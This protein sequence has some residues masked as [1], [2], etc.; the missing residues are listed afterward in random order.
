MTTEQHRVRTPSIRDVASAAGV[1]YQT[2]SRVINDHPSIRPETKQRVVEAM[3]ALRYRPNPA[4]RALV[5]SRSRTIGAITVV[6]GDY[7]PST[8][9]SAVE[10]AAR[11]YGYWVTA[12]RISGSD[13]DAIRAAVDHLLA[14]SVEGIIVIAPQVRIFEVVDAMQLDVPFVSSEAVGVDAVR[15]ISPA[16]EEGARLATDHL[17]AL[18]HTEIVHLAGPQDWIEAESRMQGYLSALADADIATRPPILGDWTSD[19]GYRAA[20]ELL[21][22]PDFSAIFAANDAMAI[23]AMHALRESGFDVPGSMSVVGFD[24]IPVSAH[25]WPPLTTVHQSFAEL[26]RRAIHRILEQIDDEV[27][28]DALEPEVNRPRLLLRN[29]TAP[30]ASRR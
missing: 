9:L 16:Q 26:G 11:A 5:T 7:G 15:H 30:H 20:R 2:V 3:A 24:D 19:F 6:R 22:R 12:A 14:Q 25:T 23:G 13:P 4:A 28:G 1:S 18:G 29:S 21:Q 10:D 27:L 8:M 17:I